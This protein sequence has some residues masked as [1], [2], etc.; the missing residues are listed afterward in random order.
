MATKKVILTLLV[1]GVL[2]LSVT[3]IL[4]VPILRKPRPKEKVLRF[5]STSP[6]TGTS[7][8]VTS[9]STPEV[10]QG[11]FNASTVGTSDLVLLDSCQ[12]M[13]GDGFCD[14]IC[15]YPEMDFDGGDC[16]RDTIDNTYCLTC[17][18]FQDCSKHPLNPGN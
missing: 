12:L 9:S 18:C 10:S 4:N 11:C 7:N 6:M 17:F 2:L 1:L 5:T 14:D 13:I 8:I 16:C 3:L 15:N